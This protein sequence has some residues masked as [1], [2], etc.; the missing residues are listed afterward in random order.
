MEACRNA[1]HA[2]CP[3]SVRST[4]PKPVRSVLLVAFNMHRTPC[5]AMPLASAPCTIWGTHAQA[6]GPPQPPTA[7]ARHHH[8]PAAPP[9]LARRHQYA[10]VCVRRSAADLKCRGSQLTLGPDTAPNPDP[11]AAM[12]RPPSCLCRCRPAFRHAVCRGAGHARASSAHSAAPSA[13]S[14]LLLHAPGVPPCVLCHA[15]A[16]GPSLLTSIRQLDGVVGA[17]G[18]GR[19]LAGCGFACLSV[20]GSPVKHA[21][22]GCA[23]AAR[24]WRMRDSQHLQ[25]G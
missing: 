7:P 11:P 18:A 4:E 17:A 24:A 21:S 22:R 9:A 25:G 16:P 1:S 10:I 20:V 2:H 14:M 23:C 19:V 5:A 12:E 13:G 3:W 6:L 8:R 15:A